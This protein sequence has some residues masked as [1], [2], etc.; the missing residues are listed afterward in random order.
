MSQA[1]KGNDDSRSGERWK[2]GDPI[3]YI[4]SD[5][6]EV[7]TPP[8]EGDRYSTPV[9]DTLD[10]QQRAELA[11][12]AI[13]EATDPLAH[14]EPYYLVYFR[15]NPPLMA[16][17]SWQGA[18]VAKFMEAASLMRI[19]SGSEQ[20]LQVDHTWM[21]VA[22]RSQGPDGLI[23]TPVGGRPWAYWGAFIDKQDRGSD[24]YG[25]KVKGDQ[26]ISP[27]GNG[28]MLS[29][30]SLFARR[31]SGGVWRDAARHLVDGLAELAV[32]AGDMAYFWPHI[33]LATKDRPADA[34]VPT[35]SQNFDGVSRVTHGLVH[36]YRLLDYEPC[37]ALARKTINFMRRYYFGH[38][39]SFLSS[40]GNPLM[41]HFHAHANTLL[42]MQEYARTVGDQELTEFVLRSYEYAKRYVANVETRDRERAE[43]P[44]GTLIGFFPEHVNSA[45]W[46]GSEICEV[47]DMIALALVLSDSG[48]GDYWDDAD[49]WTRNMFAEGQL[50]STDWIYNLPGVGLENPRPGSLS[51]SMVD[52]FSTTDRVPERNLGAFAG[53]PA[54]ND[55][56]VGNGS[57][58]MHCCTVNGARTLYW[59]WDRILQ[60]HDGSLKVNLLLNRPSPWAD[61][62]S[63]IPYQGRVDIKIK[64]AVRLEVRIPEW[65]SQTETRCRVNGTDRR[66]SWDRRYLQVG[67]VNPGD[68][69]TLTF[70]IGERTDVVHIEKER[71]TLVR[72]G[73]DVVSI[74]PPGRVH[75][76][77]QRQH[78][79]DNATRWRDMER[80]VSSETLH[81]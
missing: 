16:H 71:F 70:P 74:D 1:H 44:G 51:P 40:P 49:R 78:Y 33:Q 72:K 19:V 20:N 35:H 81:W 77:Y 25:D 46:E 53:W 47:A 11:L 42:A 34:E 9:P 23:Y 57:G 65:V 73:N 14:H 18:T 39:G 43:T 62:E 3:R 2:P 7:D 60:H 58:I 80:F 75:P 12:H 22:L 13:T 21:E 15:T 54:A 55:W 31:D 17:S 63:H 8:Y 26:L 4:R 27:F 56:Y 66:G 10:L 61:V 30:M 69:V 28:R 29:T 6:P 38:D 59:I 76:L 36:A 79:R 45:E 50:L 24:I 41:A 48:A 67:S 52:A 68:T 37:L 32:D 64:Q 5:I